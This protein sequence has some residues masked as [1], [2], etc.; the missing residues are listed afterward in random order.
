MKAA[1]GAISV[2]LAVILVP[3]IALTSL[4]VDLGRVRLAKN[5]AEAAG[6][7][8]L[9]SLL[10]HYDFDLNDFYGL[11][12][13]C[14]N[15]DDFYESSA[16][17]FARLLKSQGLGEEE[18]KTL[19]DKAR[20]LAAGDEVSDLLKTEIL[21]EEEN[22]ITPVPGANLANPAVMKDQVTDFMK[23][24]APANITAGFLKELGENS[25]ALE[26][27]ED[28]RELSEK[29]RE[30][31][32][33]ENALMET[34]YSVY[35]SLKAYQDLLSPGEQ[36]LR[37]IAARLNSYR[38][39]YKKLHEAF[40][41]DLYNTSGIGEIR[42]Q[43]YYLYSYRS[44]T[45]DGETEASLGQVQNLISSAARAVTSYK[46]A[47]T[48]IEDVFPAYGGG[49]Y[50]IQYWAQNY[51]PVTAKLNALN[52][53]SES[54][55]TYYMRL[56]NAFSYMSESAAESAFDPANAF[57]LSGSAYAGYDGAGTAATHTGH[58]YA[59]SSQILGIYTS[60]LGAAASES[61]SDKY[62]K[63]IAILER[64]STD[65]ANKDAV[66]A[67]IH[68]IADKSVNRTIAD[69]Y[70]EISADRG[71]LKALRDALNGVAEKLG[72][73][74][75]ELGEYKSSFGEW[76]DEASESVTDMGKTD[77]DEI[78]GIKSGSVADGTQ[79]KWDELSEAGID[80]LKNRITSIK[81]LYD[82]FLAQLDAMKYGSRPV[83]DI[84]DA[85]AAKAA[86]GIK[87][88]LIKQT[89]SELD[90]YVNS[91]F[92]FSPS[93][94]PSVTP[95]IGGSN[96]PDLTDPQD[97]LYGWMS[98]KFG[99]GK[100]TNKAAGDSKYKEYM[101][102]GKDK[103]E[104][105]QS[106]EDVTSNNIAA[107]GDA[108]GFMKGLGSIAGLA[109]GL[110]TDFVGEL[111]DRRDSLFATEY[112]FNMF[113][114]YTFEKEG[115]YEL[116]NG[117]YNGNKLKLSNYKEAYESVQKPD[118]KPKSWVSTDPKDAYN[119][120]LTTKMINNIHNY[121]M[122]AEC[123]YVLYGKG[124]SKENVDTALTAMYM[125]RY[126]LNT[127]SG[128]MFFWE[129]TNTTAVTIKGISAAISGLTGGIIPE[130]LIR[131]ML[132][133]F[134]IAA[135][136][137]YDI[138]M[139]KAGFPVKFIKAKDVDGRIDE[140][141]VIQLDRLGAESLDGGIRE[142]ADAPLKGFHVTYGEYLYIF[143][144]LGFGNDGFAPQ[145]YT[146]LGNVIQANM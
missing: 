69:I 19:L 44:D 114:F 64:I 33:A 96:R 1:R 105:E 133:L 102:M 100:T 28:D 111:K 66:D 23:Y 29:K 91:S 99:G 112:A 22:M 45:F 76:E 65:R 16:G 146:R 2:F 108:F 136:S 7:L 52:A 49:T 53:A 41:R 55:L 137:A 128:F 78:A 3:C 5:L 104:E 67:A 43:T 121:A 84:N 81:A 71:S 42:K 47:K 9:N 90:A 115:K 4:F 40:V 37:D 25:A 86:S 13:S 134:V 50:D 73:M 107:S 74:K 106:A 57:A 51:A 63:H 26:N 61:S 39:T 126:I 139:L 15:I 80:T 132:I 138:Q 60:V 130:P 125:L 56:E 58:Y 10:T 83:K 35:T 20:L 135:E 48:A 31:Y 95:G 140:E 27:A 6:D 17:Y 24:R 12:A 143:L 34:A 8:A 103:A 75:D 142:S 124:T 127:P 87:E 72:S 30:Y 101:S 122:G 79:I 70:S 93:A 141:W 88:S 21:T 18:A 32:E 116:L 38:E 120:S 94:E 11:V 118:A 36:K 62:L 85:S 131:T 59:L 144:L 129:G 113:S 97:T 123:E 98:G 119:K 14:R 110:A 145:M 46:N 89:K 117:E 92:S 109:T 68:K 82:D 54:L 77:K